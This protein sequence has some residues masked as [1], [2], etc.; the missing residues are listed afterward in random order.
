M[1]LREGGGN[2]GKVWLDDRLDPVPTSLPPDTP[3]A[4]DVETLGPGRPPMPWLPS[5]R[6]VCVGFSAE[7]RRWAY[8]AEERD[9]IRR[10]LETP[11]AKVLH[12]ASY[13]LA[14]LRHAGFEVRGPVHDTLWIL[15]FENG[16]AIHR[17][18]A[19]GPFA[20]EAC[21]PSQNGLKPH[22][23]LAYCANDA[24][25][26]LALFETDGDG[27]KHPLYALYQRM[28]PRVAE[29]ALA[30]LPLFQDRVSEMHRW[31]IARIAAID[32]KLR[33]IAP[34]NWKSGDQVAQVLGEA[35]SPR[36]TPSGKRRS[37]DDAA[38][39][40]CAHPAAALLLEKREVDKLVST[41]L[42]PFLGQ[43]RVHGL[44]TLNGTWTGRTSSRNTNLQNI[45]RTLR[46]LFGSPDHDWIKVDFVAAE[47]VV[48]AVI[49][50]CQALL[51][52]FRD[53]RDPHAETA[54]RIFHKPAE[55]VTPEERAV[56]KTLNFSL[57]Y[58]GTAQTIVQRATSYG[59]SVSLPEA[60]AF[61]TA[62]F[63]SFPEIASWQAETIG[64]LEAGE[65]IRSP[66]GRTWTI[67]P[68]SSHQRNMALNAPIQSAASDLL[69][70]GLDA[71]WDRLPGL[72]VNLVHDELD[73]LIPCGTFD[74]T[75][76]RAIA[77]TIAGTDSRF[78][79]RV[80]VAVGP[81][82]G[83]TETKF[84]EPMVA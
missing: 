16:M 50:D 38:L 40:E 27:R 18:K 59:L 12:N 68:H 21:L 34:I 76:W 53:G 73:V 75:Q 56:G 66:F 35:L 48:A 84:V 24:R 37:A 32:M 41:Y 72:V 80:E 55:D 8:P 52:W 9:A 65:P 63:A 47:L 11:N 62:W 3:L 61:R 17:L 74:E 51:A 77:R 15:A 33:D 1:K 5:S 78:P 13:D 70:F 45:P 26:T 31:Y 79:M 60:E 82:W 64:R 22:A 46:T 29:V 42:K 36:M 25:N 49:A 58:G 10:F 67:P 44:T 39:R 19:V 14:W 81:D 20:Y 30:G 6:L 54:G 57:C 4:V 23:V 83:S 2:P 69:L 71:V 43:D 28:A 7:G